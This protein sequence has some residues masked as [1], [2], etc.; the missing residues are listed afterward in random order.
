M[1]TVKASVADSIQLI[2]ETKAAEQPAEE[3]EAGTTI[4]GQQMAEESSLIASDG[5][6]DEKKEEPEVPTQ[7]NEEQQVPAQTAESPKNSPT[8]TVDA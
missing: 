3:K 6:E 5:R 8:T 2:N 1:K 7:K 4:D